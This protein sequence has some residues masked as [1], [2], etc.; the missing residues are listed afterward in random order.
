MVRKKL[1][2]GEK[3]TPEDIERTIEAAMDESIRDLVSLQEELR[4]K[5]KHKQK[6]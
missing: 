4:E 5:S 2:L 1:K 3:L 6:R